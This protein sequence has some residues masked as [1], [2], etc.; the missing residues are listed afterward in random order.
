MARFS[1][2][3]AA[4]LSMAIT[5]LLGFVVIP[6]L[7]KLHYGQTIKE[8]GPTWH[9]GKE[10]T[11]TMGG[12]MFIAGVL[13]GV[14]TGFALLLTGAPELGTAPYRAMNFDLL[15]GVFTA[16]AFGFVGF[17]DDYIKVVKKRNLGLT[18]SYKIVM[19]VLITAAFLASMSLNGT[20]ATGL[21]LPFVGFVDFGVLYYPLAF[22]L[23]IGMVNGVN[24]TD[25]LDGLNSSVTFVVSLGFLVFAGMLGFYN[26]GLLAAA[27]AGGCAG[28]LAWNFY[29][30]KVFMG[31]TGSMFLG[32]AVVAMAYG[33]R[34]P[35]LLLLAGCVYV[36]EAASVV[37]QVTYFKLTHG[38]RIFKMSPIHHH[39]E[40]SGWSE[41]KVG[42]VFSLLSLAGVVLSCV[43]LSFT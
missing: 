5:V 4:L 15:L 17:V 2:V 35:E 19:Q 6:A 38:K 32:G 18:A 16:L 3:C 36:M 33:L 8:I 14:G 13:L 27:V 43:Y 34:H 9:K 40:M 25:G 21:N 1:F 26:V 12:L 22:L 42:M 7:K 23:I 31:D 28:F 20:L 29:P 11:P 30:A 41:V 37:I 24:L 39:F 10:G